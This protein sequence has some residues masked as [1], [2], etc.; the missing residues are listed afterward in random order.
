MPS[1]LENSI[2]REFALEKWWTRKPML[3][4]SLGGLSP[5]PLEDGIEFSQGI[6]A[7]RW[8]IPFLGLGEE[9]V[10][11]DPCRFNTR[12]TYCIDIHLIMRG[13]VRL[14]QL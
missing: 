14:G 7:P 3:G 10:N 12:P 4:G 9:V 11:W 6:E 8:G 5:R 13:C 1:F 2:P